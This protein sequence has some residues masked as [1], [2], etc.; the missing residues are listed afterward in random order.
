VELR[1]FEPMAIAGAERFRA[2]PP[3]AS[4]RA[5][6]PAARAFL[7][8]IAID[9]LASVALFWRRNRLH[10]DAAVDAAERR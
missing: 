2:V 6:L 4:Q 8:A 3:F 9:P 5:S 10:S 1:G 7:I